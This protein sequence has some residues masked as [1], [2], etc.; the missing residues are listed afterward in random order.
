MHKHDGD[1]F[2]SFGY[3]TPTIAL[4]A[5]DGIVAILT[6]AVAMH[7]F[8][9]LCCVSHDKKVFC[10]Y[11]TTVLTSSVFFIASTLLLFAWNVII[12]ISKDHNDY[13]VFTG[14][15]CYFIFIFFLYFVALICIC[16]SVQ[17]RNSFPKI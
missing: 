8:V 13:F 17:K 14:W 7:L 10:F 4:T 1:L 16:F 3:T 15:L 12:Q 9:S 11:V 6:I 2:T 5:Y